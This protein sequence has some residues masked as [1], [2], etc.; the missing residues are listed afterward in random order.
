MKQLYPLILVLHDFFSHLNCQIHLT[1][2]NQMMR[3]HHRLIGNYI[4]GPSLL[5]NDPA[6][7][8]DYYFGKCIV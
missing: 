6:I 7:Y 5:I 1:S 3:L 4:F 2:G 8:P